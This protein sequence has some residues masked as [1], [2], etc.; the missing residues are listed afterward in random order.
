[1]HVH[2]K[3]G[4][5]AARELELAPHERTRIRLS[6]IPVL[7][8]H[9]ISPQKR[10]GSPSSSDK[11]TVSREQFLQHLTLIR[12]LGLR[13]ISL[14]ELLT[15]AQPELG[16]AVAITFDD[17]TLS[18]YEQALPCL[19]K[20]G[21]SAHFFINTG[22]VGYEGYMAWSQILDL[23]RA[24]M[25]IGSHGHWHVDHSQGSLEDLVRQMNQ[26]RQMLEEKLKQDVMDFSAPYGLVNAKLYTAAAQA[27]YRSVCTSQYWP[28]QPGSTRIPRIALHRGTAIKQLK[29]LLLGAPGPY[30]RGALQ[31]AVKYLPKHFLLRVRPSLLGVHVLREHS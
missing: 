14:S 16:S 22:Q 3:G 21:A 24:G 12:S 6:G 2:S 25:V 10:R 19:E 23:K 11:Y 20:A 17:G 31:A 5:L 13:I 30:L 1:M 26:S 18:D 7:L 28:A 9:G 27:G 15:R 8:Y 4:Y 29:S